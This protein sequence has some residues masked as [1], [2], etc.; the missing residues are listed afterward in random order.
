MNKKLLISWI[1]MTVFTF[2]TFVLIFQEG[3][4]TGPNTIFFTY[5]TILTSISGAL[6]LISLFSVIKNTY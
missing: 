5:K 4:A 2:L 1:G 6:A 3:H